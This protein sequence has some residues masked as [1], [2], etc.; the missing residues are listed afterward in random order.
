MVEVTESA[1]K[2]FDVVSAFI[3]VL[4]TEASKDSLMMGRAAPPPY[5][6][7]YLGLNSCR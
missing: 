2:L 7:L 6:Q 3:I 5:G 4:K 1:E